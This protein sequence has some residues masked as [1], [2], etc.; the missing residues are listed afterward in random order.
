MHYERFYGE[1]STMCHDLDYRA[2]LRVE[3]RCKLR[4]KLLRVTGPLGSGEASLEIAV[5][6]SIYKGVTT[7]E[8]DAS[9]LEG[10]GACSLRKF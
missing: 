8:K 5:T 1:R 2:T 9:H 7:R 10:S 4:E 6:Q 3:L